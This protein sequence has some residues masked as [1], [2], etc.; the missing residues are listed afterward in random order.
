MTPAT[1]AGLGIDEN[2]GFQPGH[3]RR[4]PVFARE[5][6]TF[7]GIEGQDPDD[8]RAAVAAWLSENLAGVALMRSLQRAGLV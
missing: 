4:R 8:R 6:V 1:R 7:L 3:S 5:L 2:Q